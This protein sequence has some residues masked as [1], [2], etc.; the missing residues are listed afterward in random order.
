MPIPTPMPAME[1]MKSRCGNLPGTI[2]KTRS[3]AMAGCIRQG[4]REIT[5][6]RGKWRVN[7]FLAGSDRSLEYVFPDVPVK[8]NDIEV[9]L[10]LEPYLA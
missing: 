10:D 7:N 1:D 3:V 2:L 6:C 8:R 5:Y 9:A 4:E